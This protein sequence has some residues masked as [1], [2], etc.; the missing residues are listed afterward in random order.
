[1]SK[2]W[3]VIK[4]EYLV[5]VK[6]RSFIILTLLGPL[7]IVGVYSLPV[8][9][10]SLSSKDQ[11]LALADLSGTMAE[12]FRRSLSE[13]NRLVPEDG[14]ESGGRGGFRIDRSRYRL[15]DATRPGESPA[16]ARTRL[17]EA[18][19]A[20]EF[21]AYL[22]IGP[23][24]D[25]EGNFVYGSRS[26]A[27]VPGAVERALTRAAV[28]E[29]SRQGGL[30]LDADE[31]TALTRP[32]QVN[33]VRVSKTGAEIS[34]GSGQRATV[35]GMVW[36]MNFIFYLTFLIWGT[37]IMR[38]VIEEKS[39]RIMEVLLSSITPTQFMVGKVT[40]IGLVALTQLAVWVGCALALTLGGAASLP[41]IADLVSGVDATLFGWFLI[42]FLLGFSIYA[43][44]FAAVGS[45]C[46]TDQE[47]QQAAQPVML[48]IVMAFFA[49]FAVQRSPDSTFAVVASL[50][51]LSSPLVLLMRLGIIEPPVWQIGLALLL[52]VAAVFGAAWLAARIFR[53][54]TLMYGKRATIPEIWRWIRA[55]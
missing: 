7:L 30:G 34:E 26:S 45:I 55:A 6:K 54:G 52:Q 48:F 50:F 24:P 41:R 12:P 51:P 44:L 46:T 36:G 35:I 2:V 8:L 21:D 43:L 23:D 33:P 18:L 17:N 53:V 47:S 20:G 10:M 31:I 27:D 14:D 29:R 25:A 15:T 40:G 28:T 9:F 38:G 19:A 13:G 4:R 3:A 22:I 11:H 39:S 5:R 49:L 32:V 1:M 16:E 42:M 37:T